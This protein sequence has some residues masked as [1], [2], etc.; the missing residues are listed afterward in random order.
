MDKNVNDKKRSHIRKM[1]APVV[2]TVLVLGYLAGYML[3]AAVIPVPLPL[4]LLAVVALAA[5]GIAMI[6]TL[7]T[8]ISEIEGGE[9]DD[10]DNY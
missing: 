1:I 4:K 3:F 9:E 2:I 5:V 7:Y 6:Y 10:L 8:R